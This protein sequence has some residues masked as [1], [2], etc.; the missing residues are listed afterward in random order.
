MTLVRET[1]LL[2][3]SSRTDNIS[4]LSFE[5]NERQPLFKVEKTKLPLRVD[6]SIL[7]LAFFKLQ[8]IKANRKQT[9]GVLLRNHVCS[10]TICVPIHKEPT[11][12]P[13]I[14]V[15]CRCLSLRKHC[16]MLEL[17]KAKFYCMERRVVSLILREFIENIIF[18]ISVPQNGCVYHVLVSYGN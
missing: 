2:Q 16:R 15:V 5:R 10:D 14:F 8:Q 3:F 17:K 1:N 11:K 7:H 18:V 4:Y 9:L 12:S 13:R 6:S